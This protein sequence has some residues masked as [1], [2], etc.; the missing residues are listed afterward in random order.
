MGDAIIELKVAWY[1]KAQIACYNDRTWACTLNNNCLPACRH[2]IEQIRA[3]YPKAHI[4]IG[5]I[6]RE[7]SKTIGKHSAD[8]IAFSHRTMEEEPEFHSWIDLDGND[9][10]DPVG[11]LCFK[12]NSTMYFDGTAAQQHQVIH[13]PIL[14]AAQDVDNFYQHLFDRQK[15]GLRGQPHQIKPNARPILNQASDSSTWTLLCKKVKGYWKMLLK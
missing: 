12:L 15:A 6:E 7:G 11:P 4:V 1:T 13:T 3:T 14:T 8:I 2:I 9:I 5:T 10:F